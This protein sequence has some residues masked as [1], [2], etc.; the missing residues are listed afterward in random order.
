M[1]ENENAALPGDRPVRVRLETPADSLPR[2]CACIEVW[3]VL[4]GRLTLQVRGRPWEL[5]ADQLLLVNAFETCAVQGRGTAAV[6]EI[7][8]QQLGPGARHFECSSLTAPDPQALR[9]LKALLARL[10]KAEGEGGE[11]APEI[12]REL[13]A[14]LY[15][16]LLG[17][18]AARGDEPPVRG[19][20]A[21][22]GEILQYIGEH[23]AEPLTL[24]QLSQRFYLTVPYLSR[25]F[26]RSTGVTFSEYLTGLR[27]AQAAAELPGSEEPAARLAERLGFSSARSFSAAFCRKY[28]ATPSA[29]RRAAAQNRVPEA[30]ERYT[31]ERL[32]FAHTSNLGPL[33][34]YLNDET[35]ETDTPV[36]AGR[37]IAETGDIDVRGRGTPRGAGWHT[38]ISLGRAKQLLYAENQ[39]LLR[40][41]QRE[42]GFRYLGFHGLLDDDMM[43]YGE[44]SDGTPQ[45]C[46]LLVDQAFDFL[47]SVGLKPFIELSFLPGALA[48]EN[49]RTLYC[50]R[51]RAGLPKDRAR[52]C[53]L[54][55][56][57]TQHLLQRYGAA[58]VE[59]WPIYLWN[60]PDLP[61][62]RSGL[63]RYEDY[64]SFYRDSWR[65]VKGCDE[66]LQFGFPNFI[67]LTD[68]HLA[69]LADYARAEGCPPD[70]VCANH[71]SITG[72]PDRL[73]DDE[74]LKPSIGLSARPD[75][76]RDALAHAHG[77]LR[78]AGLGGLPLYICEW[79]LSI[80]H[81]E[82]LNDTAFKA[83]WLVRSILENS[84]G[85]VLGYWALADNLEEVRL[86]GR[87]FHGGLGL[88]ASGGIPKAA[89]YAYVLLAGLGGEMLAH[90]EGWYVTRSAD[91]WQLLLYNYRH[92][93]GL[94]ASGELFDMTDTNRY[95]AF[96]DPVECTFV[97]G[98]TGLEQEECTVSETVLGPASGSAFD[99]WAAL[100]A[101]AVTGRG[102]EAFLRACR[103]ALR[104][105]TLPVR[106]GRL[107]LSC[108]LPPHE[109]RL[110][111][112]ERGLP[113][114]DPSAF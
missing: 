78:R 82:L 40:R 74:Q 81:R 13:S 63:A 108:T 56:G 15:R 102:E 80:S 90:G 67:E 113:R 103:P 97:A 93:N 11:H 28:G 27:L 24:R 89:Y 64:F 1:R 62:P 22:M 59:G 16:L 85:A 30:R 105:Y 54:L 3:Y 39:E 57:L 18:F 83:C 101:P 66:K 35:G 84:A 104:R 14:R 86:A 23:R 88:F 48:D 100:G 71:F 4:S 47:L 34:R 96:G 36:R 111:R 19:A 31:D 6:F 61:E 21:H 99:S 53:A 7:D 114:Q 112:L 69:P 20:A 58:E 46:F 2:R 79:N 44:D 29:W 17:S 25:L 50:G 26:R 33:A 70:F 68:E 9:R 52:W 107:T 65:A 10:V 49:C 91:G 8:P 72:P 106:G 98:L 55:R 5:G 45:L 37:R 73:T 87:L 110:L 95:T 51:S 77:V 92:Y 76:L 75:L 12:R 41:L 43:L 42:V 94:Y 32:D 38:L 109:I 60:T